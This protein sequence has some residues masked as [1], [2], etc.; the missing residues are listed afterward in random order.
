MQKFFSRLFPTGETPEPLTPGIY[1]HMFPQN[2]ENPNRLHLRI[3]PNGNGLLLLNA[4][5]VLHLN[6]TATEHVFFWIKGKTEGDAAEEIAKRGPDAI[7]LVDY[8]PDDLIR[9]VKLARPR[10]NLP[11]MV[12]LCPFMP[13]LE[14]VLK[15][16]VAAGIDAVA[17]MDSIG[18]VL[19]VE[20]DAR[21]LGVFGAE[22]HARQV[23]A[24]HVVPF[25]FD[26]PFPL[27]LPR[28]FSLDLGR[29]PV[30][31]SWSSR[32]PAMR[33]SGRGGHPGMYTST[34]TRWSA[35][36]TIAYWLGYL[37]GP[38]SMVQPLTSVEEE[39]M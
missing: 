9:A 12:K 19:V 30:I 38:P 20:A 13:R 28:S 15:E 37:N 31:C 25:P 7:S 10:V 24:G 3:E 17:A 33:A 29:F 26:F 27:P 1:H 32:I 35:P 36:S 2:V 23:R 6:S 8:D 11:L 5:T 22:L 21:V 39:S 14:E 16:L 34:G 4:A 18:P